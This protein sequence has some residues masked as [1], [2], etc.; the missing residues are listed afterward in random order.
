MLE[1]ENEQRSGVLEMEAPMTDVFLASSVPGNPAYPFETV[2]PGTPS[3]VGW[4]E[5]PGLMAA[6]GLATQCVH[7]GAMPD[8]AFASVAAPLYQTSTFAFTDLGVNG[9]IDDTRSGNP[10]RARL[11]EA[12]N[13]VQVAP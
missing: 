3:R 8:P 12:I 6:A 9:G 10:T 5:R 4:G 7:A 1:V 11:E 13:L 2:R